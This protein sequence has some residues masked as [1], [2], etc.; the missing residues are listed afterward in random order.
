MKKIVLTI[1]INLILTSCT[2][3][4]NKSSSQEEQKKKVKVAEI[5]LQLGIAYMEKGDIEHA[6]QKLLYAGEKAP[7]LPEVWY[8]MAYFQEKIGNNNEANANYLK[9]IQL[10]P[11]RGDV[12][13]NYGT[14]LCRSGK[15]TESIEH[16]VLAI[17]DPQYLEISGAY[18]NA[19]LCALKIPDKKLAQMYFAKALE[20]D[21]NR[22]VSIVELNKLR[23]IS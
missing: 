12:Q 18:E 4:N 3:L 19:G 17:K 5:N 8:T 2:T 23:R 9:A 14:F 11:G 10:A 15:F 6:K 7:E 22:S 1:L 20:T 13:N 16:F 21:P